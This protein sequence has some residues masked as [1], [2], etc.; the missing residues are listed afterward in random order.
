VL[1]DPAKRRR[2]DAGW[3]LEEIQQGHPSDGGGGMGGFPGGGFQTEDDLFAHM[4][5]SRMGGFPGGGSRRYGGGAPQGFAAG[6]Y[7]YP[8]GGYGF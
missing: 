1:S 2:Y 6:G 5:A 8:G 4:F 7:G 3:S